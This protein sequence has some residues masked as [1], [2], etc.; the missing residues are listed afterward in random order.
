M[1]LLSDFAPDHL[2]SACELL[3]SRKVTESAPIFEKAYSANP[4][5]PAVFLGF[6]QSN[7]TLWANE[8]QRLAAKTSPTGLE[9]F[10]LGLLL[11][12]QWGSQTGPGLRNVKLLARI[13]TLLQD[14]WKGNHH[15]VVG[16][17]FLEACA[18]CSIGGQVTKSVYDV[19]IAELAG[20]E[21]YRHY[22]LA[23]KNGWRDQPPPA[24]LVQ[25][26]ARRPL[27]GVLKDLWSNAT[28][29]F[30]KLNASGKWEYT[31]VPASTELSRRASYLDKWIQALKKA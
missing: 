3:R 16:I 27:V 25:R 9:K 31:D 20:D 10:K 19:L 26:P 21:S 12:Y 13:A 4:R 29:R 15:P 8:I 18:V 30:G 17:V 5:D 11:L 2:S 7:R 1:S 14:A 28:W 22:R 23:G 6:A 24:E